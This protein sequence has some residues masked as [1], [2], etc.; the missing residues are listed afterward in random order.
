MKYHYKAVGLGACNCS[1]E[2]YQGHVPADYFEVYCTIII[3][4]VLSTYNEFIPTYRHTPWTCEWM[5][6]HT[7][8]S[9]SNGTYSTRRPGK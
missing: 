8:G 3:L 1:P 2:Q 5:P 7:V 4:G 6:Y 9:R